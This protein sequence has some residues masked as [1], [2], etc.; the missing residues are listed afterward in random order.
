MLVK[1]IN[2]GIDV[3]STTVKIIALNEKKE[4]LEQDYQ[5]HYS[6]TLKTVKTLLHQILVKYPNETY[7]LALTGSGAISLATH[8]NVP[9]IQEVIAC[10]K[11]VEN[12]PRNIDI[13]VELGGEDAKI[14]YFTGGIEQ[15]MNGSCA[16][17]TG[18]FLDQMA[19]LLNTDTMGLNDLAK[20]GETIYP[21]ASRC[22]V[23]AKTDIQP[24]LNEGV[25]KSDIALSIMQ[26]VVN[27]TISGLACGKPLKGNIIFLGGPLTYLTTLKERFQKT[28]N[29][30]EEEAISPQNAHLFVA[31]GAVLENMESKPLTYEQ[32]LE[33]EK[34]L[35]FFHETVT[36]SL[37]PLFKNQKE[38]QTFL[39]RH[40][41]HQVFKEDL[42]TYKGNA[43]IGIDAGST[44]A[45]LVLISD[46]GTILYEDYKPNKGTP[47]NT[48]KEMLLKLYEVL[49]KSVTIRYSGSTGYGE[50]LIKTAFDLDMSEIETMAH[51]A[52]AKYFEPEVTS[53]IDI[54]GQDMKYIKIK[55][56]FVDT[57]LLN[58][59]CSSGCGSFIE[60]LSKSLNISLDEFVKDAITSKNPVDLGSRCTVFM[61]SKIKQTQKEGRPLGDIFAGLS[62]SIVKN[63][64]QKVMK[65]RNTDTL[66]SHIVVQGGTFL[67]DAILRA[68]ELITQK[69]VIRP[70]IAGLMGAYGI[71][72][73]AKEQAENMEETITS[74]ILNKEQILNLQMKTTN[75]RCNRCENHCRLTIN[76]FGK[77]RFISGNRCERGSG[78]NGSMTALPN[79]VSYKYDRLF[80]YPSLDRKEASRGT[81]GIPRVLNMYEDYPFWHTLFTELKFHVVLSDHSSRALFEKAMETIPSE[82]VCYP[83]KMVH[84]HIKNLIDKGVKTIF[85][86]CIMYEK[87]EFKKS[88][89]SYNCPIVTS[90]SEA[91]KL[92]ME[93]LKEQNITYLNPFLPMEEEKLCQR[94]LELEEMK[95][96]KFTKKELK[97]AI[98]KATKAEEDYRKDI[99]KKGREFLN[100]LTDHDA[101]AIVLAGRPYHIDKEINHGIDTLINSLGLVVLTEDAICYDT[102]EQMSLRVVDQWAYHARV[103]RAADVASKN[104]RLELV[105]LNSFGCGLD[106]IITDQTEEI[107]KKNN[108]LYTTIKIDETS[109]LGAIK[110]RLRSL[111]ASMK[112]RKEQNTYAPYQ[113][114]KNY[115]KKEMKIQNTIL[116]PDL[117]PFHMPLL[118]EALKASGY[119]MVYLNEMNDEMLENGLKYVNNDA[120]YPSLIV[121]GQ[122]ISALKSNKYDLNHTTVL[123]TQTGGGCRATNYIGLIRKALKDAGFSKIPI[124][125]FNVNGLEKEQEFK[126]TLPMANRALMAIVLGDLLMKLSYATRPYEKRKGTTDACYQKHLKK[127]IEVVKQGHRIPFKKEITA[128]V[129]DFN[130]I[131]TKEEKKIKVGIVGEILIKYH[132][133][134][135]HHLTE[136]LE[137]EGC[138]V[139]V[140]ELMGFVKYC[141]YNNIVKNELLKTS[142]VTSFVSKQILNL[143]SYYEM[144]AKKALEKTKYP[145][146]SNIYELAENVTPI[147]SKGNQTGE[148]WFLT[149]EMVELLKEG[150]NNIICVQPFACLPNHIVGKSVIKKMRELYPDANIIAV[151]YDPGSSVSNQINR[152]KLLLSVAKDNEKIKE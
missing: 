152:I 12:Y 49:P 76:T 137:K 146:L 59:A 138:E 27:Q 105:S 127:S 97:N 129:N 80:S 26:A 46:T 5:R 4:V 101:Y 62:Y 51:F 81:I 17:G 6:D 128:I 66:G 25:K 42:Q 119:H 73:L 89:N 9:F 48:I 114:E 63:A 38:Y 91:I 151:D 67:N 88:D 149:A 39:K 55:D 99:I 140:P 40:Q 43:Y 142:K 96:Y 57:I 147:L 2:I 141:V 135:N 53:I 93:M 117:S 124:L 70:N 60:T 82:S 41:K 116:C 139:T 52:S 120:C 15:R 35:D 92:N 77:K 78:I 94:M 111:M 54:G 61:N 118:M 50:G 47:V 134:G 32:M 23:F 110:I 132:H 95:P 74:T 56:H 113:Y 145:S 121:I 108:R 28:L 22:G 69:E 106:A 10:K 72:L 45:K 75:T 85:Y 13:A 21:I 71:A 109:N 148:G 11:A 8:L 14:I 84:G 86:P 90:Y 103:Y 79:M 19:V 104:P 112:K 115:F 7:R 150:I 123:I 3:G 136:Y 31:L 58:E 143:V 107:M 98:R 37:A 16:G 122:L 102:D 125:S 83:A 133:Y 20:Q 131:E 144:T 65:I 18:A 44:T 34:N 36:S 30:K 68:F 100:Y 126:I 1:E 29:L 87:K 64:L 130:H 24:L 33:K